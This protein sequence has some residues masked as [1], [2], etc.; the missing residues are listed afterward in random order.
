[1]ISKLLTCCQA[2]F[3]CLA[4][5]TPKDDEAEEIKLEPVHNQPIA[6][7]DSAD[8]S[9]VDLK[10]TACDSSQSNFESATRFLYRLNKVKRLKKK[11]RTYAD[12]LEEGFT[13][14]AA[15]NL[16]NEKTDDI[17]KNYLLFIKRYLKAR[18]NINNNS[19]FVNSKRKQEI[20]NSVRSGVNKLKEDNSE[21]GNKLKNLPK[22]GKLFKK[23]K[24]QIEFNEKKIAIE[25]E[26]AAKEI[27]HKI[28]AMG[29]LG[30]GVYDLH[31][32]HVQEAKTIL[33]EIVIPQLAQNKGVTL[34][35]GRGAHSP[36]GKGVLKPALCKYLS[37]NHNLTFS[38]VSGNPGALAIFM[39]GNSFV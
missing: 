30:K 16:K 34:I 36:S 28:N 38:N 35:T 2:I 9:S 26:K 7:R 1:M 27:F 20:Y 19:K 12:D 25:S 24:A 3:P 37:K 13:E 11:R 14:S 31:G 17:A 21:L 33:D 10:A 32:L 4:R 15:K 29:N 22:H 6:V 18:K 39:S 8:K 23:T 5:T